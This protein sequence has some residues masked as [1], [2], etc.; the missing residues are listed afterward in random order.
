MRAPWLGVGQQRALMPARG[1]PAPPRVRHIGMELQRIG[2]AAVTEGL[3]RERI[4]LGQ[5]FPAERQVEAFAM[6][7]VDLLRPGIA[8]V[9]PDLGW[10]D[11]VIADLGVAVGVL[12]DAAAEMVRQHLRAEA[13]AEKRLLFLEWDPEPIDLATDEIVGV[14]R[15]H[16]TAEID[17]AGM[18][19]HGRGQRIAE[20]R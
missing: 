18:P 16:R 4:A 10:P 14:V 13:D 17:G 11:R 3:H 15:A 6:P 19:C 12:V 20:T 1:P 7:L 8:D 9:A 2:R 5:Q